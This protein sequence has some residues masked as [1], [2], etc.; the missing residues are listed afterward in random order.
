MN[1]FIER[2]YGSDAEL[3]ES[4]R[5]RMFYCDHTLRRFYESCGWLALVGDAG[6]PQ[7]SDELLMM[8]FLSEKGKTHQ[9]D[10][11]NTPFYFGESTW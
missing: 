6:H 5:L 4:I 1:S 3:P 8:L 9:A 10:F 7:P 11:E 2:I